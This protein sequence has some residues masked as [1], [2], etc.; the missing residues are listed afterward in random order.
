MKDAHYWLW[1]QKSLGY[2]ANIG[3]LIR[4]FGSARGVYEAGE[5]AWRKSGLFGR[6]LFDA[7]SSRIN[8]LRST[9]LYSCEKTVELCEREGIVIV[10]PQDEDYP[11]L[12]KRIENFPAVLF[13]KGDLSFVN[14]SSCVAVVGTRNPSGYGREAA[15]WIADGL[16]KALSLIH[17]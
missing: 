7:D 6:S 2:G 1:L 10:T 8:S 14:R 12:L 13:V 16:V 9:S 15:K 3:Y 17:I 11:Q 4:Y 5:N